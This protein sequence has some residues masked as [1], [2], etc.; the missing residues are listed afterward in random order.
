MTAALRLALALAIL[1][2]GTLLV[3]G[4]AAEQRALVAT[5]T[6]TVAEARRALVRSPLDDRALEGLVRADDDAHRWAEEKRLVALS[7]ELTHRNLAIRF[8]HLSS[9]AANGD[10]TA[11]VRDADLLLR[12]R[13]FEDTVYTF[14]RNASAFPDGRDAIAARLAAHPAWRG[15][16]LIRQRGL[17]PTGYADAVALL[18]AM[19]RIAPPT[20]EEIEALAAPVIDAGDIDV[21]WNLRAAF[22]DRAGDAAVIDGG[23]ARR[24]SSASGLLGWLFGPG[25][26]RDGTP[27]LT[28]GAHGGIAA[29]Q[30][31]FATPGRHVLRWMIEGL[32][33]DGGA[34][35][36]WTIRCLHSS[37]TPLVGTP[38]IT[39]RGTATLFRQSVDIPA[40]CQMQMLALSIDTPSPAST[41]AV[42]RAVSL[43]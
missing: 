27:G 11:A 35:P 23:F 8:M 9:T 16:L 33:G 3:L 12:Q 25:S 24:D 2:G 13:A 32:R 30:V 6:P 17:T 41:A 18:A 29:Q 4:S 14:L 34:E 31:I 39:R 21:A 43:D 26:A 36:D 19:K 1:V 15:D 20:S 7:S 37:T 28:L 42:I 10:L 5:G 40:T 38:E 22:A